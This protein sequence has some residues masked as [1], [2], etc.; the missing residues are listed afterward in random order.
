MVSEMGYFLD[1]PALCIPAASFLLEPL[2]E[3][4]S[5]AKIYS[6]GVHPNVA[7]CGFPWREAHSIT[8]LPHRFLFVLLKVSCT[9][10]SL[11][12]GPGLPVP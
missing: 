6:P 9:P 8:G 3:H 7:T 5:V 1:V 2:R 11:L 10:L 4:I 12:S